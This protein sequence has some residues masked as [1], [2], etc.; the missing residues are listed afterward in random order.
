MSLPNPDFFPHESVRKGQDELM[1]HI[2]SSIQNGAILLAHAPT[3]LGKTA[4]A[5]SIALEYALQNKKRI[6]FLTNRHTQ[7]Q[8]AITTLKAIQE[9]SH[10]SISCVDL[11]GKK[12]MCNQDVA[13]L[14]GTE[15]NEYCHAVV[16]KGE[17]EFYSKVHAKKELTVDAK[18]Q[19]RELQAAGPLHNEELITIGK[20][21]GMCSYELSLAMAKTATV[22]IG[23]YYYLF[24]PHVQK[25]LLSKLDIELKDIIV[26]VD[27]G[28]NL[29]T[30]ITEML[31]VNLSTNVLKNAVMEAKKFSFQGVI[32]WIQE[33]TRIL[34]ELA[35][36]EPKE[37]EKI[38]SKEQF[39]TALHKVVD[40][41]ELIN[42]LSLAA[43]EIRKKQHRSYLGSICAF[44][45]SWKGEDTGF[46]RIISE[47]QSKYGPNIV[48]AYACLDPSIITRDIFSQ[49]HAGVLMSGTLKPTFM[50]K[51]LLGIDKAVEKEYA[52]PFP[53]ENKLT[54]I[55]PQTSTKYSA[56]SDEMYKTIAAKCSELT[57]LVS[58]NVAF[59]FP[60][61][62][63]RDRIGMFVSS[64]KQLFWEKSEMSKEDKE[65]F[66]ANFKSAKKIGGVL[67]GV[68]GA[69]FAE[70]VDFP[71]DMLNGVVVVGLPLAHPS[72]KTKHLIA[73]YD[74]KFSKGWEYGYTYP[75]M[76]KCIQSAG[77]CIRSEKD[78]GVLIFMDERFAWPSYFNL[79]P[80]RVGLIVT[81][82]YQ[83]KITEFFGNN[84]K[85]E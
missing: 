36:F 10:T 50:Y 23:D 33:I 34:N 13:G 28:H 81:T 60:S 3:G 75:A 69:N 57:Q 15:F 14:F 64:S 83:Q 58:G 32:M 5:L 73:Y 51:D 26:I 45:E 63:L 8:I 43:D 80:E 22:I 17:C 41:D 48:L 59:F 77:R 55:I 76:T 27:E 30:R 54:I 38:I 74:R 11:I 56:R 85:D 35:Q 25:N 40:S 66:L 6:F 12:W 9:K 82:L 42:E 7:H 84:R 79:F 20:E 68:S 72:V 65:I 21:K 2:K 18:L 19:L 70:G 52:S 37:K 53:P 4:S 61:Y 46:C 1:N 62:D 47:Q 44:L 29:P 24:N 78:R 39:L 67:L 16:E 71:G 31:S 49:V